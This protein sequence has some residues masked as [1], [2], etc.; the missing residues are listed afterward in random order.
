MINLI[1]VAQ[2]F[3][4]PEE[5]E[6]GLMLP[7]GQKPTSVAAQILSILLFFFD[8][9]SLFFSG[10]RK[11]DINKLIFLLEKRSPRFS[12]GIIKRTKAGNFPCI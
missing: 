4:G 3:H 9:Y 5:E 11:V 1:E 2:F 6:G 7:M 8:T 12:I 10:K